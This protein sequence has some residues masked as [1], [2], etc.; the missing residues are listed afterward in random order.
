M[1]NKC[2]IFC[3]IFF[4]HYIDIALFALGYFILPQPVCA[5]YCSERQRRSTYVASSSLALPSATA[6]AGYCCCSRGGGGESMWSI[7]PLLYRYINGVLW[8][9]S[10]N[11]LCCA[12]LQ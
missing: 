10:R 5:R 4:L 2:G 6:A 1:M 9:V 7:V 8:K 11:V 12:Q 3:V